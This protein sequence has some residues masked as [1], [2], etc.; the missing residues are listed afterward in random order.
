MICHTIQWILNYPDI[1]ILIVHGKQEV[2]LDMLGA[3]RNHFLTNPVLRDLYPDYCP[4]QKD[5]GNELKFLVKNRKKVRVEPTVTMASIGTVTAGYHFDVIKFTDI[6]NEI[7]TLTREQMQKVIA[8]FGMYRNV[9]VSPDRWIDV[10]GTTYSESDLYA[11]TLEAEAKLPVDQRQW[12][13]HVRGAYKKDT[14]GRPYTFLPE[15]RELRDLVDPTG[16]KISWFP[17]KF[18]VHE[19]ERM[20]R[21]PVTGEFLFAA[22]QLNNPIDTSDNKPFPANKLRTKTHEEIRKVPIAY[23]T[24]TVDFAETDKR[25][26]D[27]TVILT[28]GWD[29]NGRCYVVDARHGKFLPDEAINQL[30]DVALNPKMRPRRI[31]VEETGYVR[32]LKTSIR[33]IEDLRGIYLPLL[34]VP[35]D[36]DRG[37]EERILLTLQP[38]FQRGEIIFDDSL[39]CFEHFRKELTSFPKGRTDDLIDALADQFQAREWVGRENARPADKEQFDT[40]F[41]EAQQRAFDMRVAPP[42]ESAQSGAFYDLTGGL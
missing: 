42:V 30:F 35:R 15:E 39:P 19:L 21:D 29:G 16:S 24:T 18:P 33:R 41:K 32:G 13:I 7:N 28:C 36:N 23:Y 9:L 17:K 3:I 14:G 2:A 25:G 22:Q 34:Y 20:R 37:K 26:S 31:L 40:Y 8:A 27:Y 6:V 10:E 38:W 11:T 1:T 5:A 4:A 12:R